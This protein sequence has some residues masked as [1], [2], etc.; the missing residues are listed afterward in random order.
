MPARSAVAPDQ[1]EKHHGNGDG[2]AA[3]NTAGRF[4]LDAY[5]DFKDHKILYSKRR[6]RGVRQYVVLVFCLWTLFALVVP[7]VR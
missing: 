3:A 7:F 4:E 6:L 2:A 5:G 1:S